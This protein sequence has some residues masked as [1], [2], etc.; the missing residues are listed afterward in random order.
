MKTTSRK[1]ADQYAIVIFGVGGKGRAMLL[2]LSGKPTN[3]ARTVGYYNCGFEPVP[4]RVFDI[5][6]ALPV[7]TPDGKDPENDR[8]WAGASPVEYWVG[9]GLNEPE[10]RTEFVFDS[11]VG[12]YN[13]S[14]YR[15]RE[16]PADA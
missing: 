12:I 13:A 5:L 1:G 16:L 10:P 4:A 14:L 7:K 15:F 11:G 9:F 8:A 6:G 2:V 3:L